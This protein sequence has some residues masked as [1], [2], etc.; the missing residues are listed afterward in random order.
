[1]IGVDIVEISRIKALMADGAFITRVFS[2]HEVDYCR[3]TKTPQV[4]AQRFAVR[5]AA[6][7]AVFKAIDELKTLNWKEIEIHHEESGKPMVVFSGGTR[8]TVKANGLETEVTLSHSRHYAVA[9]AIARRTLEKP[10]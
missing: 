10:G 4:S 9:V 5:F 2:E 7:E 8:E 1:M 3:R 6:K